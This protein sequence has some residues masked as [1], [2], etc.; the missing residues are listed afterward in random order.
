ML[1]NHIDEKIV[2]RS[3]VL[4]YYKLAY[5]YSCLAKHNSFKLNPFKLNN[6]YLCESFLILIPLPECNIPLPD[7][8]CTLL[9]QPITLSYGNISFLHHLVTLF[10][11]SAN[12]LLKANHKEL[13]NILHRPTKNRTTCDVK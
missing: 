3:Y 5:F 10:L 13:N 11:H 4:Q 9:L 6:S 1:S 12:F 8:S 7:G 2:T